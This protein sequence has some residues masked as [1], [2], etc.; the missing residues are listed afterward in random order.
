MC[1]NQSV[2]FA[3]QETRYSGIF[4][5]IALIDIAF[6]VCRQ[7]IENNLNENASAKKKFLKGSLR[8]II[9]LVRTLTC[10]SEHCLTGEKLVVFG[11]FSLRLIRGTKIERMR[12]QSYMFLQVET[13]YCNDRC[14]NPAAVY[15]E[16]RVCKMQKIKSTELF[17][18]F[19]QDRF[20]N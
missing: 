2:S 10:K 16:K 9:H 20:Q 8:C 3:K 12:F 6:T 19:G 18:T 14:S 13:F 5:L 17:G 1:K 15:G 7:K 11:V 4:F